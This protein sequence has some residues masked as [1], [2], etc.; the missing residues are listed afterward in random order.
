M[1]TM[2]QARRY[3]GLTQVQMAEK[4]GI[5]RSSYIWLEAHPERTTINQARAI[6]E[7]TGI[8]LD[9]IFFVNDST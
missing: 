6:S 3:A 4:L 2:K 5:S 8:A 1:F 7:I 9:D